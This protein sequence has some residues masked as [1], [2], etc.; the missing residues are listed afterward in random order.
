MPMRSTNHWTKQPDRAVSNLRNGMSNSSGCA[1][2][3]LRIVED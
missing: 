1:Q 3:V 2:I